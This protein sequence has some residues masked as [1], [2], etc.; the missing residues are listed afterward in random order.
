[1]EILYVLMLLGV[2]FMGLLLAGFLWAVRQEQYED[3]DGPPYRIIMDDDDPR[4]P[5]RQKPA[6]QQEK[7]S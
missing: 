1:M 4:I 3:M 2:V 7:S 5:R 6:A